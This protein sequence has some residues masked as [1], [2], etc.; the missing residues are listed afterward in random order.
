M[1]VAKKKLGADLPPETVESFNDW[2]E[3]NGYARGRAASAA[4]KLMQVLPLQIRDLVMRGEWDQLRLIFGVDM[5]SEAE[6][7]VI[8]GVR[9]AVANERSRKG[10]Q[11]KDR[12]AS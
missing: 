9:R 1:V 7:V 6:A 5:S 2:C 8:D 11:S 12:E 4:L 3:L 10:H